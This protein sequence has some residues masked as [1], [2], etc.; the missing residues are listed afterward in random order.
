M[1]L[2]YIVGGYLILVGLCWLF[3]R[4]A[5]MLNKEMDDEKDGGAKEQ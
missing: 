3:I 2:V 4:G 1:L 5:T